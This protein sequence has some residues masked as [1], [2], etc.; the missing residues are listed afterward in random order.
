MC[1]KNISDTSGVVRPIVMAIVG[2]PGAGKSMAVK[3]V[4]SK[5]RIHTVY[6][7][8]VVLQELSTRELTTTEENESKVRFELREQFGMGVMAI[9]CFT[10][11]ESAL[12]REQDVIIDGLYS[13]SEYSFLRG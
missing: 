12:L 13:Y 2:M 8:G 9:K 10:E 3:Y 11:I 7:G 1:N 5:Y 6:F 4:K